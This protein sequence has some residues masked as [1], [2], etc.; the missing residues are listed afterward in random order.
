MSQGSR[1][2]HVE[3]SLLT[4]TTEDAQRTALMFI[5]EQLRLYE[6]KPTELTGRQNEHNVGII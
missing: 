1:M 2:N 4:S 5:F 6:T 3:L